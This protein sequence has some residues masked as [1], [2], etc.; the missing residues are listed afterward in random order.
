[1]LSS[2]KLSFASEQPD[3]RD[4]S[5]YN[6]YKAIINAI[7]AI[8]NKI[9]TESSVKISVVKKIGNSDRVRFRHRVFEVSLLRAFPRYFLTEFILISA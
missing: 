4:D 8:G 3:M 6:K 5:F 7:H 2:V 1:M 9:T